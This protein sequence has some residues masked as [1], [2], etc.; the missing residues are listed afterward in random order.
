MGVQSGFVEYYVIRV[1]SP[2]PSPSPSG[3]GLT[4]KLS[5]YNHGFVLSKVPMFKPGA[6]SS[7]MGEGMG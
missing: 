3:E 5:A 4:K 1:V 2:H 6:G 7:P